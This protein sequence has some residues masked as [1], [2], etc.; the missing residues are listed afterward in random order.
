MPQY[1]TIESPPQDQIDYAEK[2]IEAWLFGP[3]M[4]LQPNRSSWEIMEY[5]PLERGVVI[6]YTIL[7]YPFKLGGVNCRIGF[8]VEGTSSENTLFVSLI[9]K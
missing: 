4:E 5:D 3:K 6:N 9:T 7:L 2:L 8:G 1:L